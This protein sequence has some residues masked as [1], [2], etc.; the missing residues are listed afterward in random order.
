MTPHVRTVDPSG[1]A[2]FRTIGEAVAAAGDGAVLSLAPGRYAERLV[3]TRVVT[4]MA[5]EEPG[6]VEILCA[7]GSA[8]TSVAEAVK[9]TGLVLRGR[10][11]EAP[12]VDAAAGQVELAECRVDGAAWAAVLARDDGALALRDCRVTCSEGAGIVVTSAQTSVIEDCVVEDVGTSGLVI[13]E[14]GAPRVRR[15]TIRDAGGN[16]VYAAGGGAGRV[17]D[18]EVTGTAK[19]AVAVDGD[20]A[21]ELVR[22]RVRD[23]RDDG[24][25]LSSRSAVRLEEVEVHGAA[26]RGLVLRGGTGP[27]ADRVTVVRSGREGVLAEEKARGLL[28]GVEVRDAGGVAVRV[29]GR[30]ATAFTGLGVHGGAAEGVV[31]ADDSTA[32]FDRLTVDGTDGAGVVVLSGSSPFLRRVRVRRVRGHGVRF[33][34]GGGRLEDLEATGVRRSGV[35][36]SGD[37]RPS[38]TGLRVVDAKENGVSAAAGAVLDLRDGEV[39]G[40]GGDGLAVHAGGEVNATRMRSHGNGRNG[41]LVAAGGRAVLRSCEL[42][43]NR[44][45]GVLVGTGE[46]VLVDGCS[47]R[48]NG[49]AGLRQT[50]AGANVTAESLVSEGNAD[51]DRYGPDA[52]PEGAGGPGVPGA[53]GGDGGADGADGDA[54]DRDAGPLAELEA[55]IGLESVKREVTTLVNRNRMARHRAEMGLP[56][57]PVARHLVFSGPPGTG[58]TTVARLYG[59]LLAD[60]DVLRY[61]HVVEAA[62]ADLVGQY[63][64]ATA[65]KTTEVFEKARGGVLFVDEAYTL[66]AEDGGGF[67]REAIDTL[68]KLM[69]D[70]R[71]D[72]VVIVAGYGPEM[73]GFL[74]SNPGLASRFARTVAFP[75]YRSEELVAIVEAQSAAHSYTLDEGLRAALLRHFERMHK[76][77]AFGNGREARKVFEQMVDRQAHRLG[78]NPPADPAELTLLLPEDLDGG[79]AAGPEGGADAVAAL[80]AELDALTGLAEVKEVVNDLVNVLVTAAR[81]RDLG[82]PVPTLSHHLVFSG[83]P[84][85]GKT[86][87][88]RIYGRLLSALGVLPGGQ[89]VEAARADLVGRYVGHTAQLTAEVFEKARGGVLFID[90]A[91]TLTPAGGGNDFGQEA[92]DT[93]VKLMEDHRDE[94]A[95]IVA[96]Y[97]TEMERFLASNPGLASR[98]AQRVPF[99]D[100][101]GGELVSIVRGMAE[102]GG[103]RIPDATAERLLAHFDAVPRGEAF[104]NA[105]YA[106][107]VMEKMITRQAGRLVAVAEPSRE[108]LVVLAPDDVP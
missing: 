85:T 80:R 68:V 70:H 20:A 33:D 88:A 51:E 53:A 96:G 39:A 56:S 83:P 74:A 106:R 105:R 11:P 87:V 44:A 101:S 9:L 57:P 103:Y 43:G 8:V 108:D 34:G 48:D 79:A 73:E 45:D 59:R 6:S 25:V 94:V 100:Y 29:T 52:V 16:G 97:D 15:C 31:V 24:V 17:E 21:P 18:C 2:E 4:L 49:R 89:T 66:S 95:V 65:I 107:Q 98:F 64:G 50:V 46:D 54:E 93:L 63:V 69:E 91:Y 5:A 102:T 47:V 22:L 38:L 27:R 13:N 55:L 75:N 81:R 7:E 58:K 62:R 82:M 36:A 40:C 35:H 86:T 71:D 12:V 41:A 78:E 77:P 3:L 67:G 61:G 92:V 42:F 30:S 26:G 84:G 1:G 76:G 32:E 37:A 60:L 90:E 72:V 99:T 104:G 19:P 23:V 28:T 10:D 14:R